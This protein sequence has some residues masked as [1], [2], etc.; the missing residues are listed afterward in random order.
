MIPLPMKTSER[1]LAPDTRGASVSSRKPTHR[2]G[3]NKTFKEKHSTVSMHSPRAAP[4]A[5]DSL[6]RRLVA[7]AF[8]AVSLF[9]G[10]FAC[11]DELVVL[12]TRQGVT[13]SAL[14]WQAHRSNPGAVVLL[15]PGGDG[16][17]GLGLQKNGLAAAEEPYLF[18]NQREALLQGN[19]AVAVIDA[20][21]DQEDLTQEFRASP[22]H[23]TDVQA[24][25]QEIERRYPGAR[26][27]VMA[28]SRGTVSAGQILQKLGDKVS[29]AVLFSG[30]YLAS[31]PGTPA[32]SAGP[33]LSRLNWASLKVPVL[34]VHHT[35]D[36]CPRSP[37][38]AAAAT[39][40]ALLAVD[41]A[42]DGGGASSCGN[43]ASNHWFA[44]VG[45]AVGREVINWL[46]GKPWKRTVP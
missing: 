34:L 28:H 29:A 22:K 16:N 46:S 21:S 4:G 33:G 25:V 27:V 20:P 17:I 30:L 40:L 31:E 6:P 32:A 19:F 44:G 3:D 41:G 43:P 18:A 36:S 26:L 23:L 24:V 35:R 13:Q 8:A 38:A 9:A 37:F 5:L 45:N 15:I 12:N 1:I 14:I 10:S 39:G 7:A 42:A 2:R 11:A